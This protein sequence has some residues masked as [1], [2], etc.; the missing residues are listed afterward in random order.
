MF[1]DDEHV[2]YRIVTKG[3]RVGFT[4]GAVY[5]YV[6][7]MLKALSEDRAVRILW[8]D[9]SYPNIDKYIQELFVKMLQRTFRLDQNY[10]EVNYSRKELRIG[11]SMIDFRSATRPLS[12][13]G[14]GYNHVFLNEA[15]II[16][17]DTERARYLYDNAIRPMMLDDPESRLIAGGVPKI[18]GGMFYELW[19]RANDPAQHLYKAYNFTSYDNPKLT[20]HSIKEYINSI[21]ELTARQEVFGQFVDKVGN[22]FA[23]SFDEARHVVE[24]P[25]DPRRDVV[26]AFDFNVDPMTCL[27]IQQ[28]NEGGR[29][30]VAVVREIRLANSNVYEMCERI[31]SWYGAGAEEPSRIEA[32]TGDASGHARSA[33]VSG[34]VTAWQTIQRLLDLERSQLKVPRS[35][36]SIVNSRFLTNALFAR[37]PRLTIDPSCRYLIEDLK[38]V[39]VDGSGGIDK[40]KDARRT[41]LLD[42][43]RYYFHAFHAGFIK[44]L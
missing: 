10:W 19:Q 31:N 44:E 38:Y 36:P 20:R 12:W 15:G 14:F 2:K 22:P 28:F 5:Y 24:T 35:N 25:E 32:V 30:R 3:R 43:L 7:M 34:S 17:N 41:H 9:V 1:F 26:L 13:E 6:K 29:E 42:C 27:V 37:H 23:Y 8:G 21:D 16:L 40:G 11:E 39:E 18:K 4:Y 33:Y